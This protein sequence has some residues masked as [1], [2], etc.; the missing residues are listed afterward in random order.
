[1]KAQDAANQKFLAS[2]GIKTKTKEEKKKDARMADKANLEAEVGAVTVCCDCVLWLHAVVGYPQ[3]PARVS[4]V[5]PP[6]PPPVAPVLPHLPRSLRR[7]RQ[8]I[9]RATHS[10]PPSMRL[11]GNFDVILD[12]FSRVFTALYHPTRAV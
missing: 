5:D 2:I 9:S 3:V 7:S 8:R 1:M 11:Y 4:H 6:P 10:W 12:H